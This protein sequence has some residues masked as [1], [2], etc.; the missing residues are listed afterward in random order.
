MST[1]SS[2]LFTAGYVLGAVRELARYALGF[3]WELLVPKALLAARVLAAE[4]QLAVELSRH[5]GG[6]KPRRQFTAAFRLLWV[7]LSKLVEGWEELVHAMKP[8]TVK[9]WHTTAFR[10]LWRWRSLRTRRYGANGEEERRLLIETENYLL[11]AATSG[12]TTSRPP[13]W[14]GAKSARHELR[15]SARRRHR[16]GGLVH[17]L[18]GPGPKGGGEVGVPVGVT[19]FVGGAT[20]G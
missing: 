20:E 14:A 9:R 12:V 18:A 13:M 7:A 6:K 15:L 2:F 5:S 19:G 8:E 4:S 1:V 10:L 11:A 17:D 3:C 16:V